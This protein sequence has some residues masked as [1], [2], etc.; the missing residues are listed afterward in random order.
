MS[1]PGIA[2]DALFEEDQRHKHAIVEYQKTSFFLIIAGEV[3]KL[4][5]T[6]KPCQER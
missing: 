2:Y 3:K 5:G 6:G 1:Q 4:P